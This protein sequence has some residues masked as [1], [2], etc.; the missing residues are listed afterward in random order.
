LFNI[1]QQEKSNKDKDKRIFDN[2]SEGIYLRD[3]GINKKEGN[4]NNYRGKFST[5]QTSNHQFRQPGFQE[6]V[7]KRSEKIIF[8]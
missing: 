5:L 2:T 4:F 1:I 6:K 8:K 7:N 3:D